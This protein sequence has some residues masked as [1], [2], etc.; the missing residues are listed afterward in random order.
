[1]HREPPHPHP[2]L[3]RSGKNLKL[4]ATE[5]TWSL[6]H[7]VKIPFI[8]EIGSIQNLLICNQVAIGMVESQPVGDSLRPDEMWQI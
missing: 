8:L 3:P 6:G 1:M 2:T 7:E 4:F 5:Y